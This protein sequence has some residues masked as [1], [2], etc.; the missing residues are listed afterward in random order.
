M[1]CNHLG[2]LFKE[3]FCR[4]ILWR[5]FSDKF[6]STTPNSTPFSVPPTDVYSNLYFSTEDV[7]KLLQ[8]CC[9][10]WGVESWDFLRVFYTF[11]TMPNTKL[12]LVAFWSFGRYATLLIYQWR[13]GTSLK[14]CNIMIDD[15]EPV[16]QNNTLIMKQIWLICWKWLDEEIARENIVQLHS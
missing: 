3:G 8:M 5:L 16:E 1:Y 10:D 7:A 11:K 13:D 6:L 12:L 15:R 14:L 2:R 9:G 4:I